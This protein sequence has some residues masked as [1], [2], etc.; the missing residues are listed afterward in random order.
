MKERQHLKQKITSKYTE[1]EC[2]LSLP[3][4]QEFKKIGDAKLDSGD[5]VG[6]IVEYTKCLQLE[7]NNT[8][9]RCSCWDFRF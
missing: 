6:A 7:P 5:F 2:K 3:D 9:Y 8:L 4:T 1:N